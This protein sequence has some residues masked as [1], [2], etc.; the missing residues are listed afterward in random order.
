MWHCYS[1]KLVVAIVPEFIQNGNKISIAGGNYVVIST[2]HFEGIQKPISIKAI[3]KKILSQSIFIDFM[4]NYKV[5][6]TI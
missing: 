6:R 2:I 1:F 4:L 5:Q 3:K